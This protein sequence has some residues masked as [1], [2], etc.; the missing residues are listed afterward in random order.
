MEFNV[1]VHSVHHVSNV[2]ATMICLLC[3]HPSMHLSISMHYATR[4]GT[5][6]LKIFRIT[7]EKSV[8]KQCTFCLSCTKA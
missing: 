8:F 2:F 5:D 1:Y 4:L 7:L 6:G 3:T